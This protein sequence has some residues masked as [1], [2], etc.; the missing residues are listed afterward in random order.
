[1][2]HH[3]NIDAGFTLVEALVAMVIISVGVLAMATMLITG[4][5]TNHVS[6]QRMDMAAIAQSVMTNIESR[7][8]AGYTQTSANTAAAAQLAN[9]ANI[10]N[11]SSTIT[12][13]PNATLVTQ[14]GS[15]ITV[16]LD[17]TNRGETRS[18]ILRSRV[19]VP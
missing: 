6:E 16:Q 4:I 5:K 3:K 11:K 2:N 9:I 18:T 1:M 14:T 7:V 17:W 12:F 19:V 13:S 10:T 8:A 15:N